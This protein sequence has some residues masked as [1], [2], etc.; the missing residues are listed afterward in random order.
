[1]SSTELPVDLTTS[2]AQRRGSV[3][4]LVLG[5]VD[6]VVAGSSL[7]LA[8]RKR[9]AV[10]S[11][12]P[13]SA[14][15]TLEARVSDLPPGVWRLAVGTDAETATALEARLVAFRKQPVALLPGPRPTTKMAPPE[16]RATAPATPGTAR[17]V[18]ARTVDS[19]LAVLPERRRGPARERLVRLGRR[20]LR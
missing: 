4:R 15:G 11:L 16:P 7:L 2:Y 8:S 18:A 5:L 17:R 14:P 19:A 13:G 12:E 6:P 10:A 1:M 9:T 20:L 3:I